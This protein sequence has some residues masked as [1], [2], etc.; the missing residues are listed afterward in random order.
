MKE[1]IAQIKRKINSVKERTHLTGRELINEAV[2]HIIFL[3][4]SFLCSRADVFGKY[5]PFGISAAAASPLNYMPSAA[6]G[7]IVGYIFP[8]TNDGGFRYI[9]AVLTVCAIRLL[10]S[11]IKFTQEKPVFCA[12]IAFLGFSP[13]FLL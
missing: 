12:F 7:C 1:N 6:L 9:A 10:T 4:S 2:I 3:L 8:A 13:V 5:V 11:K